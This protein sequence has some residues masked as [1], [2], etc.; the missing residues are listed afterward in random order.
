MIRIPKR[1]ERERARYIE[2]R[3]NGAGRKR[4][5]NTRK[6]DSSHGGSLENANFDDI[7]AL[8]DAP[9]EK[10]VHNTRIMYDDA[11]SSR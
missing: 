6:S 2:R 10:R 3:R 8:Y 1:R 9:H 5:Y 7:E 11:A 4:Q